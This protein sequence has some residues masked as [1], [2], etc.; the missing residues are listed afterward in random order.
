MIVT[1]GSVTNSTAPNTEVSHGPRSGLRQR[2][3]RFTPGGGW[4]SS[5]RHA[6]AGNP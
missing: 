1:T 5:V 6:A 2:C 4:R 3:T